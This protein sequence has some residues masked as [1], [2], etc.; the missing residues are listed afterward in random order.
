M[1]LRGGGQERS[2]GPS[3]GLREHRA[4]KP[5]GL[6]CWE[7]LNQSFL[8]LGSRRGPLRNRTARKS[9]LRP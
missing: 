3:P 7:A 2:Q 4:A 5:L 6:G 1:T 9:D 8:S